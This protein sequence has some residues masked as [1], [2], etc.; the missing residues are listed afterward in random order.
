MIEWY[1]TGVYYITESISDVIPNFICA[2]IFASILFLLTSQPNEAKRFWAFFYVFQ[3]NA[4][5]IQ[6]FAHLV[7]LL[8]FKYPNVCHLIGVVYVTSGAALSGFFV[9]YSDFTD[10]KKLLS[11]ISMVR[12]MAYT[13]FIPL[14]GFNRCPNDQVSKKIIT[15]ELDDDHLFFEQTSNSILQLVVIRSIALLILIFIKNPNVYEFCLNY[16]Q[17]KLIIGNTPQ[18]HGLELQSI[19]RVVSERDNYI[20]NLTEIPLSYDSDDHGD[21]KN[22]Q[23]VETMN[24]QISIAWIDITLK[25][26]KTFYSKEKLILRGIKGFVE[27]GSFTALMGPS[28]AG[29]TSLLKCLNGMH[30]NLMTKESK[31]YLSKFQTIRTC[32]IAQDQREHIINGLTVKQALIYASKLKNIG[33]HVNHQNIINELMSDLDLNDIKNNNIEKCSS[34]QQKRIVMAMELTSKVKPNLICVDEPTSGVDCFSAL[35]VSTFYFPI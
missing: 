32:F 23:N 20:E 16:L 21:S 9:Q 30:R 1:S 2:A 13:S 7:A 29:K 3:L 26:N 15:L 10:L 5:L 4:H 11:N 12:F 6:G 28:G 22:D 25:V 35:M 27:F 8:L 18:I 24:K 33:I 17:N 31:I 34:G 14:Y 19:S